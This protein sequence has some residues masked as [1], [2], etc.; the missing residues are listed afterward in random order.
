V[1]Q[2]ATVLYAVCESAEIGPGASVGPFAYLRPG[3][4]IGPGAHIGTFVELKNASVGEGSKVPHLSYVGDADIGEHSN[5]GAATVFANYDGA[6]KHHTTVGDHVRVGSVPHQFLHAFQNLRIRNR[7][8]IGCCSLNR[9]PSFRHRILGTKLGG[10]APNV[11]RKRYGQEQS[12]RMKPHRTLIGLVIPFQVHV[13]QDDCFGERE[14][15]KLDA[16]YFAGLTV[17][18]VTSDEPCGTQRL[19]ALPRLDRQ[20]NTGSVLICRDQLAF[21]L[22]G[23]AQ[24][25]QPLA[26]LSFDLSLRNE[27]S[28]EMNFAG[29]RRHNKFCQEPSCYIDIRGVGMHGSFHEITESAQSSEDF[30]PTWL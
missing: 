10:D 30:A 29:L 22:H 14:A 18:A 19:I 26:Q 16:T 24:L 5:I 4:R 27:H 11:T 20:F 7:V 8:R 13:G 25:F 12:I 23:P 15:L 1:A 9:M 3:T 6:A 21:P 2:D 28:P 17:R